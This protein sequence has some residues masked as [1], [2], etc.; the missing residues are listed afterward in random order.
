MIVTEFVQ[1]VL[2]ML[3]P[4]ENQ[5]L[6]KFVTIA[7]PT[8]MY[9]GT[10]HTFFL[11]QHSNHI[12]LTG[13]CSGYFYMTRVCVTIACHWSCMETIYTLFLFFLFFINKM[14]NTAV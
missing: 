11:N 7:C 1:D 10:M 8:L 13:F 14:K 9:R 3:F 6:R 12:L 4:C 2:F 5:V